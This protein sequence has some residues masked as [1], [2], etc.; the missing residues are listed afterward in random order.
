MKRLTLRIWLLLFA[1]AVSYGV[2][3]FLVNYFLRKKE[4]GF[5]FYLITSL[6]FGVLMAVYVLYNTKKQK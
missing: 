4:Y 1:G 2:I 3:T 6:L 5:L